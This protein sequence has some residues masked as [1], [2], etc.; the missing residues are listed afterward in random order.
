[1][2][3]SGSARYTY[4]EQLSS[5]V[6]HELQYLTTAVTRFTL[7]SKMT[8]PD[9]SVNAATCTQNRVAA[10]MAHIGRYSFRGTSRLAADAGVSK[11]TIS[12]LVHG[13]TN[14]LYSTIR[15]VVNCLELHLGRPLP[16][17]EVVSSDGSY[18]TKHVCDLVG[19][20]GCVPDVVYD[21]EGVVRAGFRQ[22]QPG[23]WTGNVREFDKEL[24]RQ[25][26]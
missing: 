13:K 20:P 23:S 4:S 16:F 8:S 2:A 9:R 12:H 26:A 21:A 7:R 5:G 25:V 19:C 11:S 3:Q 1:M 15:R 6:A 14:P 18:P 22:V 17:R 24:E 10:I